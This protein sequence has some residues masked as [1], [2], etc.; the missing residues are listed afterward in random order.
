MD[1]VGKKDKAIKSKKTLGQIAK[2][3]VVGVLNTVVDL[4]VLNVLIWIFDVGKEG[5]VFTVFKTM[6]FLVAVANSYIFNRIWVFKG[7]QTKRV[8]SELTK[9]L[10][11]SVI[12]ALVNV[13]VASL[14]ANSKIGMENFFHL[15][16]GI[17]Q[18]Y[19][20]FVSVLVGLTSPEFD[21]WPTVAGLFSTLAGLAWNFIGYKFVVFKGKDQEETK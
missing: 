5:V 16:P 11:V 18:L 1:E 7:Q 14:V 13:G 4:V 10:I 3:A 17:S 21:V 2:F 20:W 9:F 19:D 8:G 6:S 12:G 15:I